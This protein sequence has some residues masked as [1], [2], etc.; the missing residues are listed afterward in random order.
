MIGLSNLLM[1]P[2]RLWR[3]RSERYH[4]GG[5]ILK[6]SMSSVWLQIASGVTVIFGVISAMASL[7][8]TQAVWLF[9]FDL[10]K[11]PVDGNPGGFDSTARALNAVLGGVMVGWGTL[12]ALLV[13]SFYKDHDVLLRRLM[14]IG[15]AAWFV[16]DSIG[17]LLSEIPG[18]VLLNIGFLIMFLPPLIFVQRE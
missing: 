17:S 13:R 4:N 16:I 12:M 8:A 5:G 1:Q 9:L 18:N 6:K 10:L 7:P 11:W 14:L 2:D 3:A 15:I